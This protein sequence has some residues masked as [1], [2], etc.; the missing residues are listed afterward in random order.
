MSSAFIT[1]LE[2]A[3]KSNRSLACVGL[4]PDPAHMAVP[5]IREFNRG[6]VDATSDLVC[7]YKPNLAFYEAAGLGGLNA[8]ADTVS[9]IRDKAPGV[10]VIGDAKRGDIGSTSAK[11][12]Q[13]MFETWGF[14]AATVNPYTGG[15]SIEP[16]LD[17]RDKGV[18]VLCRSS[19]PGA[20][21]F[22]GLALSDG[23]HTMPLYEQVA[24]RA[25]SWNRNGNVGLVVGSTYPEEL[26]AVRGRCPDMPI[27]VPG[28]GRQGG[29]LESAVKLGVGRRGHLLV[30]SSSRGVIYASSGGE[31]YV[32]AARTA[33]QKLR[34]D[35]NLVLAREGRD[36]S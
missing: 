13:A 1:L 34:D 23:E 8:L 20:G 32:Q 7:A 15:D 22:Q 29:D 19:N 6:I 21:E 18:F 26:A 30:I 3:S 5:D 35:I 10:M 25:A 11:Y 36:W 16:F 14:D 24:V 27:L 28:V 4:D 12:A 31:D 33:A 17:Y 2:S 9:H